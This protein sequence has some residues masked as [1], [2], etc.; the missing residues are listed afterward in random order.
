MRVKLNFSTLVGKR[1]QA[2]THE[3]G[4]ANQLGWQVAIAGY[5]DGRYQARQ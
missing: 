2:S 5:H 3:E 1:S 4:G